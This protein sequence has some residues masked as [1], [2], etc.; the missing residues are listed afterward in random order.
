MKNCL[1]RVTAILSGLGAAI[2]VP[3]SAA[4][5]GTAT[6]AVAVGLP[7]LASLGT[8]ALL[9]DSIKDRKKDDCQALMTSARK[10]VM[11][12]WPYEDP[13]DR[14]E[15][16]ERDRLEIALAEVLPKCLPADE[17]ALRE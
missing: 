15:Q 12:A 10:R 2:A 6:T 14:T 11:N 13:T 3:A 7:L 5:A 17:P 4:T 16:A 9:Y 1:D 8:G